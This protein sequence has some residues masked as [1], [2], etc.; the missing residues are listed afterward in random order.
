MYGHF[1]KTYGTPFRYHQPTGL[2]GGTFKNR[3]AQAGCGA[4]HRGMDP[5]APVLRD[6]TRR[7]HLRIAELQL[8][9]L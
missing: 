1:M 3:P 9:G 2:T 4:P 6:A 7:L 8:L 5:G